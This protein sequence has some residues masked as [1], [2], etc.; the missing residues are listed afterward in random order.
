MAIRGYAHTLEL[1]GATGALAT[2]KLILLCI[3]WSKIRPAII[4]TITIPMVSHGPTSQEFMKPNP[5]PFDLR[6]GVP[7]FTE[8]RLFV[9]VPFVRCNERPVNIINDRDFALSQRDFHIPLIIQHE[10]R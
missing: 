1:R 8:P 2:I 9:G 6:G 10:T 4:Q 7:L 5:L 3:A